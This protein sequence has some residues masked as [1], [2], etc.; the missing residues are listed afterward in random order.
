M[1]IY[2]QNMVSLRCK[3][4]VKAELKKLD[5]DYKYVDLGE[6]KLVFPIS[7]QKKE[8]L[9]KVLH[10]SGLELKYQIIV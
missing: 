3:K 5:L 9:K 7:E 8:E 2:I 10:Q 6:V 4:L 1:K